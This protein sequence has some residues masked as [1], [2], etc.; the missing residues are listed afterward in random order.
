M[1][2][3]LLSTKTI[4]PPLRERLISRAH[5]VRKLEDGAHGKLVVISAPAGYGKTS[6]VSDWATSTDRRTGWLS[7]DKD[8]NDVVRFLRYVVSV[9]R[10]IS[11]A[12]STDALEHL[13]TLQQR[14]VQAAVT[15]LINEMAAI[16][17]PYSLVLDDYHLIEA[18]EVHEAFG[19]LIDH[20]PLEANVLIITRTEPP[21]GIPRLRARSE[22]TELDAS[23][24]RFSGD[25]INAFMRDV[26][27]RRISATEL[28]D[29]EDLTEGWVAA[30]Q[31]AALAMSNGNE[32]PEMS[33]IP[34]TDDFQI[35][36]FLAA[37]VLEHL[38]ADVKDFLVHT[39]VLDRMS[40]SLCD[41]VTE[42]AGSEQML[43][44]LER[45]NMFIIPL[46]AER[47][48]YRYHSLFR[49]FLVGLHES[50]PEGFAEG[51]HLRAAVWFD[52]NG[53]DREAISHAISA[54]DMDHVGRLIEKNAE[55]V[56]LDGEVTTVTTWLSSLSDELITGRPRLALADAWLAMM[57]GD[58]RRLGVRLNQTAKLLGVEDDGDI[59]VHL[60][61]EK[62]TAADSPGEVGG[63]LAQLAVLRSCLMTGRGDGAA[64]I[65]IANRALD[66]L[67]E[68]RWEWRG[69]VSLN[70]AV[71]HLGSGDL[72]AARLAIAEANATARAAGSK[73]L[74]CYA[75]LLSGRL[76][77]L[78]GE[79]EQ[80]EQ[81]AR[82]ALAVA[83]DR[84]SQFPITHFAYLTLSV[85]AYQRNEL[86]SAERHAQ[87][88]LSLAR[89]QNSPEALIL[90]LL[91][92]AAIRSAM[93]NQGDALAA[94]VESEL[95][96]READDNDLLQKV[97]RSR[98][99][100]SLRGG[101]VSSAE[102]WADQADSSTSHDGQNQGEDDRLAVAEVLIRTNSSRESIGILESVLQSAERA[103]ANWAA[104]EA[105]CLLAL[106][107]EELGDNSG[108]NDAIVKALSL[109][110]KD[111]FIRIFADR[112]TAMETLVRRAV[113]RGHSVYLGGKI[114]EALRFAKDS[115]D[116]TRRAVDGLTDQLS[117]REREVLQ[118][119]DG[120]LSNRAI[121]TQ[122]FV[123]ES[124]V[125]WHLKNVYA[126][127]GVRTRTQATSRARELGLI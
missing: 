56:I 59:E 33:S 44:E 57:T 112:G 113:V 126:K 81:A 34:G 78:R 76:H 105:G 19:Y 70:L 110:E 46:D 40:A 41:A 100:F 23:D 28:H 65:A 62:W 73:L 51:C 24:L 21:V 97:A 52:Q 9:M 94:I 77:I 95:T 109:A 79:L 39:S 37:E 63:L 68:G 20:L 102:A 61:S 49:T 98:A 2:T 67:P 35:A 4:V 32:S 17:F 116:V 120:G 43:R 38:P 11:D 82:D 121:S 69:I 22:I 27:R 125:K 7:L 6:L 66:L 114:L 45:T 15:T 119:L 60:E 96:A 88:A 99:I 124:T 75:L 84:N 53:M 74:L 122:L 93:G 48:W 92:T 36:D 72:A 90:G 117:D 54:R 104:M 47:R 10:E 3:D 87:T 118:L 18:A 80:G 29:L 30:V 106:A 50:E 12:V 1:A 8:D 89:Q 91:V 107:L 103:E 16:H 13:Q 115:Q 64:S 58:G 86:D 14:D 71:A 123:A 31:L 5:L 42:K 101:D 111:G 25:E 83:G 127:L 108:S 55:Q 26:M 85:S